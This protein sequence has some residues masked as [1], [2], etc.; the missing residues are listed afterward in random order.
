MTIA[1]NFSGTDIDTF[2]FLHIKLLCSLQ[3]TLHCA[4][5]VSVKAV[6]SGDAL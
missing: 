3:G 6:L 4:D 1:V 5:S 2:D